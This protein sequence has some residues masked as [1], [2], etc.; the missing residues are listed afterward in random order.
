MFPTSEGFQRGQLSFR[1]IFFFNSK[2]DLF[3][4]SLFLGISTPN[5]GLNARGEIKSLRLFWPSQP[6]APGFLNVSLRVVLM[7]TVAHARDRPYCAGLD[8]VRP[9][10][11]GVC[12]P[13]WLW[14]SGQT[15]PARVRGLWGDF[16]DLR[17]RTASLRWWEDRW[18]RGPRLPPHHPEEG[19]PLKQMHE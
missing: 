3:K 6:G 11:Q 7:S 18:G 19:P 14:L 8:D 17:L 5:T 16:P 9:G 4:S 13:Q 12:G 2:S 1:W 15:R 10:P